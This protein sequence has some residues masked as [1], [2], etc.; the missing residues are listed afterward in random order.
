[1]TIHVFTLVLDRAPTDAELTALV[2]AGR[3]DVIFGVE[4]DLPV[5]EFDREAPA[6]TDAIVSA[7]RDVESVGLRPLRVLDQD[8]LT[9][10]DI[11]DRIGRSRESVRRYATGVRGGG[12][13]ARSG[14]DA[15]GGQPGPA[16][17]PAP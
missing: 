10:A 11:A 13:R 14:P 17:P 6:L 15:G 2:D 4:D 9:L 7:I 16:G 3:D 5:A 12:R 1:M 8:L